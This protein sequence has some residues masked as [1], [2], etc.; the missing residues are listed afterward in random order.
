MRS[1]AACLSFGGFGSRRFMILDAHFQRNVVSNTG[2]IEE[3]TT[4]IQGLFQ[5]VQSDEV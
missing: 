5:S 3:H 2:T 1:I 4:K